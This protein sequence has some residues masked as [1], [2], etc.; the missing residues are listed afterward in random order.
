[1]FIGYTNKDATMIRKHNTHV[2]SP[3]G[4]RL[5]MDPC[6]KRLG[7]DKNLTSMVA[8]RPSG[9]TNNDIINNF[10]GGFFTPSL[11]K[12]SKGITIMFK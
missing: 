9:R 5:V 1:M 2:I 3:N 10:D 11:L 12:A 4:N 7:V 6:P 8:V